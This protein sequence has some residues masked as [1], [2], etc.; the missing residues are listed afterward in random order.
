LPNPGFRI[1]INSSSSAPKLLKKAWTPGKL[2]PSKSKIEGRELNSRKK[3]K[4]NRVM[5]SREKP[6]PVVVENR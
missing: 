1:R 4:K 6:P 3:S 5:A 2:L